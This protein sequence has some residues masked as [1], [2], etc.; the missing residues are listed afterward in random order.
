MGRAI[1]AI[2]AAILLFAGAVWYSQAL[3][4]PPRSYGGLEVAPLTEAAAAR[5]LTRGAVIAAVDPGS[6]A[7]KAGIVEGDV[8]AAIDGQ[9]VT[10]ARQA[11]DKI[12]RFGVGQRAVLTLVTDDDLKP[13]Q[14]AIVFAAL[15][16]PRETKSWLV[17]PQRIL[18]KEVFAL[19]PI[20]A[21][22]AWSR[23]LS[24]GAFIEPMALDGLGAGRCNG[25]APEKWRIAGHAP[26]DS[27]FHVMAPATFQ[28][29]I[30]LDAAL[31]GKTPGDFLRGY[32]EKTFGSAAT[33]SLAEVRPF[34]FT[35]QRFGNARGGAGFV[36]YRVRDGRIQ[37]WLAAVAAAESGWALPI[38]AAVVFSMNCAPASAPRDPALALTS[39]SAQCLAGKC[40]DSDFAA[41]YLKTLRL[42]YV[43][44]AKEHTYLI[45]PKRD[46]WANGAEGPGYYH[47]VSGEN[48]KLE[49]GRTN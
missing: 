19:P 6:P 22:A 34:G 12:R 11:A 33:L 4:P 48:E 26:D 18:A 15:P 10:S 27:M 3:P 20:A 2:A 21:N 16:D 46:Y 25:F 28:H 37:L 39:V 35:L 5:A 7:D 32:L 49:P 47:Q 13:K 42:G 45:N 1:T 30:L 44:D 17:Y 40:Q 29:A 8:L 41:A 43:H 38:T 9:A 36:E 14:V 23:R 31:D 24:R